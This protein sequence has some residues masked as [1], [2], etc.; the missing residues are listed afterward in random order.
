[1]RLLTDRPRTWLRRWIRR[2]QGTDHG[3]VVLRRG[4]IYILPTRLGL[5]FAA[6][7]LG[8]LNYGNN[9]G[10]G[11]TFLLA[12]LGLV[13]MQACHRNLESLTVSAA[14]TEPP[15]A[16]N[17]AGFRLALDNPGAAARH[18]LEASTTA[19]AAP[20]VAVAAGGETIVTLRL[21]TR[22]RGW[23][24]LDRIE[25][26]TRHPFGLFRAWAVLHPELRCLVY[27]RPAVRAP[28]PPPAPGSGAGG[29]TH[30]GVEDF[31]GLKDYH[32]GD[33]PRHIAWKAHARGGELLVKQFAGTAAAE[34]VFDLA[35]APGADLEQRLAILARWVVDADAAGQV[36]GLRLPGLEL[37]PQPGPRQRQR[38]L[39]ALA[40]FEAPVLRD[41]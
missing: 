6:M 33:P 11:L 25:L 8:S 37:A 29:R 16:G 5:A 12:A 27:P 14:G 32:P 18:D 38:C 23:V 26:A 13:A 34:P 17:A 2:R 4:R 24:T 41:A 3:P 21:P 15:F 20:P 9:L 30:R 7:L 19:A 36:Y 40:E 1:M 35:Q 28:A 10:L 22:R 39:A 31:A